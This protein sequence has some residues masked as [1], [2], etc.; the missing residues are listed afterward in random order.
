ML[1]FHREGVEREDSPPSARFWVGPAKDLAQVLPA[2]VGTP[3][4]MHP[5]YPGRPSLFSCVL[6]IRCFYIMFN[7]QFLNYESDTCLLLLKKGQYRNV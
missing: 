5:S 3:L 1:W 6:K 4:Q 7:L 2:R